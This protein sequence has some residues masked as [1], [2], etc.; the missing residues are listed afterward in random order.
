MYIVDY[1][2]QANKTL[3]RNELASD[4]KIGSCCITMVAMRVLVLRHL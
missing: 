3:I 2:L 1:S 4:N